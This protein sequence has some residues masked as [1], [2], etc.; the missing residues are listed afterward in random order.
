MSE[1]KKP[2]QPRRDKKTVLQGKIEV[3]DQKIADLMNKI[4]KY[5]EEKEGLLQ[6]LNAIKDEAAKEAAVKEQKAM[7][8][9]LKQKGI[10]LEDLTSMIENK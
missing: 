5:N 8:K 2:R 7:L 1:E 3:I 4:D 10:T 9:L 6:E